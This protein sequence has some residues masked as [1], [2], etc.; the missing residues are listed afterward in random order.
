MCASDRIVLLVSTTIMAPGVNP[1]RTTPRAAPL[2]GGCST[3]IVTIKHIDTPTANSITEIEARVKECGI[4]AH[5]EP[6]T[7]PTRWPPIPLLGLA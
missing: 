5:S 4:K 3:S 7:R 6:E 1:I 2:A